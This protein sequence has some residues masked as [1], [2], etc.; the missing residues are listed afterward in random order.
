MTSYQSTSPALLLTWYQ[1]PHTRYCRLVPVELLRDVDG[2][3]ALVAAPTVTQQNLIVYPEDDAANAGHFFCC[4]GGRL[5]H[6]N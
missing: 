6:L 5:I 2:E 3:Q 1:E 4:N